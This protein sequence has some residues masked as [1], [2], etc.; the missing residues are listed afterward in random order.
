MRALTRLLVCA[1]PHLFIT[2]PQAQAKGGLDLSMFKKALE[3]VD[4]S[5]M[6][7]EIPVE[8]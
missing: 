1:P 8:W 4:L 6:V 2:G 7:V 5:L 3:G